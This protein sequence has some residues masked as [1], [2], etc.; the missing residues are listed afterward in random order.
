MIDTATET[1][2]E[3]LTK[4]GYPEGSPFRVLP[5]GRFAW[6][7]RLMFT[8]AICVASLES[9]GVGYDDRWCFTEE[10]LAKFALEHWD[11]DEPEGWIRNPRTG[12][13]RPGGDKSREY[14]EY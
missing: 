14:V 5:D 8:H 10:H 2:R 4:A 12:R 1:A 11:G 13:R 3:L 7:H 9:F 6:I